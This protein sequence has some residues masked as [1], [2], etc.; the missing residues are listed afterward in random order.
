MSSSPGRRTSPRQSAMKAVAIALGENPSVGTLRGLIAFFLAVVDHPRSA[1]DQGHPVSYSHL[2]LTQ[3]NSARLN[4]SLRQR[5]GAIS[6]GECLP[7]PRFGATRAACKAARSGG[8]VRSR[9]FRADGR[10]FSA[11]SEAILRKEMLALVRHVVAVVDPRGRRG[12]GR[13][14]G[15]C[16]RST[17]TPTM[18][19]PSAAPIP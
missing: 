10:F 11:D 15:R 16:S 8:T 6:P 7:M 14:P 5:S 13:C 1:S 4:N 12:T 18:R 3:G 19:T 2:A 9:A 17:G